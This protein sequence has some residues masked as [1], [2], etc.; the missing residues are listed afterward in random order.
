MLKAPMLRA[1]MHVDTLRRPF[2]P[3]HA[4]QPWSEFHDMHFNRIL[5]GIAIF[6]LRG[7]NRN[8]RRSKIESDQIL[9]KVIYLK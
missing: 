8:R 9:N 3:P 7:D 6:L 4:I 1:P 2:S 5:F